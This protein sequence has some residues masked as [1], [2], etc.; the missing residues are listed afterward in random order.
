MKPYYLSLDTTEPQDYEPPYMLWS[1]MNLTQ[2]A[3]HFRTDKGTLKH[4][5]TRIYERYFGELR[6]DPYV[7]ETFN[8]LSL[9]EIGVACGASLKMWSRY[10]PKANILGIDIN[11]LCASLCKNYENIEIRIQNPAEKPVEGKFDI[12]IDDGSHVA[13]DMIETANHH[14]RALNPGGYYCIEDTG[15]TLPE[16]KYDRPRRAPSGELEREAHIAGMRR[17]IDGLDR[18][19][20]VEFIHMHKELVIIRKLPNHPTSDRD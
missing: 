19:V 2:I 3:D 12:I 5:Y 13:L 20:E 8:H 11:P 16:R 4:N 1:A 6:T 14:W 9:M 18:G 17:F 10:F 15:C 7:D